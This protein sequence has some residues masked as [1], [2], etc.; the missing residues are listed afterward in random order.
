MFSVGV[1]YYCICFN[2]IGLI[3]M[4]ISRPNKEYTVFTNH[5]AQLCDTMVDVCNLLPYF[6]QEKLIKVGDLEEINAK[7][8]TKYKVMRLLH[9]IDGPLQAGSIECFYTLLR[10]MERHGTVSTAELASTMRGRVNT[11]EDLS[12]TTCCVG[13][14]TR[15]ALIQWS[16]RRRK[17]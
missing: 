12:S 16:T 15:H 2:I 11:C 7:E 13:Q 8:R 14:F 1:N 5:Y 4:S 6:V 3:T 9:F 10:I 17:N